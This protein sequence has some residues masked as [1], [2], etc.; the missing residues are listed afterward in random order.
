[1]FLKI[2]NKK[3][4]NRKSEY[5]SLWNAKQYSLDRRGLV[6]LNEQAAIRE[7]VDHPSKKLV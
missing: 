7:V 6:Y 3:V 1:M 5:R 4:E 2:R